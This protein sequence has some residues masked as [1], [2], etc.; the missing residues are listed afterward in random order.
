[1]RDSVRTP[2]DVLVCSFCLALCGGWVPRRQLW[3]LELTRTVV[4]TEF[5]RPFLDC[6]IP[7][8]AQAQFVVE[9]TVRVAGVVVHQFIL[10]LNAL[11]NIAILLVKVAVNCHC[12]FSWLILNVASCYFLS[13]CWLCSRVCFQN[14][15]FWWFYSHPSDWFYFISPRC[16]SVLGYFTLV[17]HRWGDKYG[18]GIPANG[19]VKITLSLV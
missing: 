12:V 18:F 19:L 5:R 6:G 14:E 3:C 2:H 13:I 7:T 4:T 15:F 17:M 11:V 1:M 8:A 9:V 10:D 16:M